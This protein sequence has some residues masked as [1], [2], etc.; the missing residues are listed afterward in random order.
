MAAGIASY[1][2]VGMKDALGIIMKMFS[3]NASVHIWE[4]LLGYC[5][6]TGY[7]HFYHSFSVYVVLGFI[8]DRE[9]KWIWLVERLRRFCHR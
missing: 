7:S 3:F 9:W 2:T 1:H 5:S 8:K 4:D 6:K